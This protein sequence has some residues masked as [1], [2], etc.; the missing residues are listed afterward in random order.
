LDW[1]TPALLTTS[2]L[3]LGAGLLLARHHPIWPVAASALFVTWVVVATAFPSLWLFVLPA[4]LPVLSFAPWTGW[5]AFDEF[6]LL[7]LASVAGG[8]ARLA[9]NSWAGMAAQTT[10]AQKGAERVGLWSLLGLGLLSVIA[11]LRGFSDAGGLAVTWFDGYAEALNSL[12]VGKSAF[13]ACALW[14]LLRKE[15]RHNQ[16]RAISY[17]AHGTQVGLLFVGL[18]ALA[19]RVAYPGLLNFSSRYRTTALFWE[20]HVGGAAIDAYLALATPFAAWA[21][22][23]AR[24]RAAWVAAALLALLTIHACLTTFSRGVYVAVALPLILLGAGWWLR[25]FEVASSNRGRTPVHVVSLAAGAAMLLSIAFAKLDFAGLA[26]S[27]IAIMALLVL[28][29]TRLGW[30]KAAG[31]MLTVAITTEVIAVVGGGSFMLSRLDA[32]QRDFGARAAHWLRGLGLISGP[33]DALF[34]IGLGRLPARYAASVPTGE[35]S[36]TLTTIAI[37]PS[38]QAARL[39]GP[40]TLEDVAGQFSMTQRVALDPPGQYQFGAVLRGRATLNLAVDLCEEHLLYERRCQGK[41]I[42]VV[43]DDG[44]WQRFTVQ[45]DGPSLSRGWWFAPRSGVLLLSLTRAGSVAEFSEVSLA[46]PDGKEAL[47]N[48]TFANGLAH[49]FPVAQ[50][51]FLPWHIDNLFLELLI[52][53]GVLGLVLFFSL[54]GSVFCVLLSGSQGEERFAAFLAASL[55]GAL[56]VGSISSIMD[57]PRVAFLLLLVI[58][59]SLQLREAPGDQAVRSSA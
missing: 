21:L 40:A 27:S 24:S 58:L 34:G 57:A 23:S 16:H 37:G 9:W 45:L 43:A 18:A 31:L 44:A 51:Y 54:L 29:G 48:R 56:L 55:F 42:H 11:L 33:R 13:Y 39:S 12:R 8:L 41:L 49:W 36:G 4:A 26:S 35:F 19:E 15:F 22:W 38:Q 59:I 6:D 20:M 47:T 30:S 1:R 10:A 7:I 53:R 14:P 2:I 52:E 46:T 3:A 25:R 17:L 28:L 50:S 5:I 32:S